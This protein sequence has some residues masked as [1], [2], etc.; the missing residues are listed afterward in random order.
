MFELVLTDLI[1]IHAFFCLMTNIQQK[2]KMQMLRVSHNFAE[3]M[4]AIT[5]ES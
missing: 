1:S 4:S 5:E 3:R 2:R